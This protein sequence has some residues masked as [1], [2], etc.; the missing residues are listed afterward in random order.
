MAMTQAPVERRILERRMLLHRV[1]WK[2]YESLLHDY[3]DSSVP[4]LTYDRGMLEIVMPGTDHEGDSRLIDLVLLALEERTGLKAYAFGSTT[5]VREDLRRGL[6]ADACFYI[7]A[8]PD[9]R[10][11][12]PI[13]LRVVAPP[14]L[15]VEIDFTSPSVDKLPIYADMGVREVWHYRDGRMRI[16]VLVEARYGEAARSRLFP[17]VTADALTEVVLESNR[18]S[19]LE[20]LRFA[21][22]WVRR[23]PDPTDA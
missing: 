21:Q 13:D 12:T 11:N 8:R 6:E 10:G 2:T 15:A 4:R 5:L 23:Q 1:S 20:R 22:D 16:L 7:G 18:L 19:Q 3:V 9:L 14:D 17:L